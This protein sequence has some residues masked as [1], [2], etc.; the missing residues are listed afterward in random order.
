M[1]IAQVAPLYESVPPKLYG[2][3]ERVVSYLTESLVSRG[4]DVTL[5]ATGDSVTSARLVPIAPQAL[6]LDPSCHDALAFHHVMFERLVRDLEDFDLVHFHTDY[7]HFS[8]ARHLGIRHVTTLHGRLDLPE[9]T[10]LYKEFSESPVIS[11]SRSQRTPLPHACWVGTVH[12]GLPADLYGF[13][14]EPKG[15]LAFLG[16]VSPEKGLDRAIEI[17]TRLGVVLRVA[18]KVDRADREYYLRTIAPLLHS[19]YVEFIGEITETEKAE[20][21]GNAKAL[22]FPIEWP[23]PFGLV[24]IEAMACG[25]PVIAYNYGSV[26]EVLQDGLT[27]FIVHSEEEAL[28]AIRRAATLDRRLIRAQFDRRFTA[29]TMARA[30]VDVYSRLMQSRMLGRAG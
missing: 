13:Q 26:P 21:L 24:L 18:A 20:F 28:S 30:Y 6:R 2:G 4:H 29:T 9:L 22:L 1:R 15:Y 10:V 11:I 23:E 19:P 25:T 14:E 12:H 7:L 27:G 17:A 3:T 16:R 8:I 5:Y